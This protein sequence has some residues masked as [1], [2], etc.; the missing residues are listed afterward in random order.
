MV[1]WG[2]FSGTI[3]VRQ[4]ERRVRPRGELSG[5]SWTEASA[6]PQTP[7]GALAL[8][9]GHPRQAVVLG[10]EGGLKGR[11]LHV[12]DSSSWRGTQLCTLSSQPLAQLGNQSPSCP[13]VRAPPT[14]ATTALPA[15]CRSFATI[16]PVV[17]FISPVRDFCV[18]LSRIHLFGQS[19]MV[20]THHLSEHSLSLGPSFLPGIPR[21]CVEG[22]L[23]PSPSF[24]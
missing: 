20:F 9:T 24:Q 21:W 16:H 22:L 15:V 11:Q 10:R 13:R 8:G 7:W 1:P 3:P 19:W 14:A 4:R 2:A 17:A 6:A 18:S 23:R 5:C 12:A